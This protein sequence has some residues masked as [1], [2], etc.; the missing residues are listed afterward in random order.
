MKTRTM[1]SMNNVEIE[2]E[3]STERIE[4]RKSDQRNKVTQK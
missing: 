4:K 2:N 3:Q 1:F